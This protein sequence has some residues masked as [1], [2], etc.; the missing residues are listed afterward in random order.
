M[1]TTK[2]ISAITFVAALCCASPVFAG[3][4]KGATGATAGTA[5]ARSDSTMAASF[6]RD[7]ERS[8]TNGIITER[9]RERE[10]P[11]GVVEEQRQ[12]QRTNGAGETQTR[13]Q[14]RTKQPNP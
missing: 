3:P 10:L 12:K 9:E 8:R 5:E 6:D 13:S 2:N 4:H 14:E 7:R 11:N 1:K